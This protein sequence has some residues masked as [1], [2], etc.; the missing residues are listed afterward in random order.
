MSCSRTHGKIFDDKDPDST[1]LFGF[2]FTSVLSPGETIVSATSEI[3]DGPGSTT[4]LVGMPI[5]TGL[6]V[7]QLI[8]GGLNK[9]TY[10][11]TIWVDTSK[12]QHLPLCADLPVVDPAVRDR[13]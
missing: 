10:H 3:T 2:D 5:V 12:S 7:N 9:H 11:F 13:D 4:M 8:T 6:F 1:E